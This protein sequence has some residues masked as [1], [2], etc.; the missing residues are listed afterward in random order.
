MVNDTPNELPFLNLEEILKKAERNEKLSQRELRDILS[1]TFG[2]NIDLLIFAIG[3]NEAEKEKYVTSLNNNARFADVIED[4]KLKKAVKLEAFRRLSHIYTKIDLVDVNVEELIKTDLEDLTKDVLKGAIDKKEKIY[5]QQ[6]GIGD[7]LRELK[8]FKPSMKNTILSLGINKMIVGMSVYVDK[9][10]LETIKEL[11]D[12]CYHVAGTVGDSLNRIVQI[13]DGENLNFNN[14]RAIAAYF[15]LTNILKN[16]RPDFELRDYRVK[17]IP[18]EIHDGISYEDL[19]NENTMPVFDMREKVFGSLLSVAEEYFMPAVQYVID[20][21]R[22]LPGYLAFCGVP[23]ALS[24]ETQKLINKSGAES[25]FKGEESAIKVNRA[26]V[27]NVISFTYRAVHKDEGIK[28]I[29]WLNDYRK[30]P[31]QFSFE[32]GEYEKWS[33]DLLK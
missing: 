12:Y 20:I 30:N 5:I 17:F 31:D 3:K 6:F 19:F 32:T 9:G 26:L 29:N 14:A 2:P 25:V 21:P 33:D 15:Q 11:R 23:L 8:S 18:D 22:K 24:R 16:L 28:F 10:K 13:E 4:G 1:R 7:A 27:N